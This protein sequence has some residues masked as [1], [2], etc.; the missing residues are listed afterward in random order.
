[1]NVYEC[2]NTACTLG[3]RKEPGRFS[4]GSTERTLEVLGL[5]ADTPHGD[6]YCPNC[7][8]KGKQ[9]ETFQPAKGSDPYQRHHNAVAARVADEND[10][11]DAEGAQEAL[12]ELVPAKAVVGDEE[13]GDTDA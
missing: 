6:G 12:M 1:M 11:L 9:V 5:P 2:T 8:E 4:G 3:N 13:D 7:A 10:P